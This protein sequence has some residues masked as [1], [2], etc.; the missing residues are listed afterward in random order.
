[1]TRRDVL[2]AVAGISLFTY[3]VVLVIVV[4]ALVHPDVYPSLSTYGVSVGT[5]TRYCSAELVHLHP[6]FSC[7]VTR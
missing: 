4:A 6:V 2:A 7:E 3:L 1:M 5:S